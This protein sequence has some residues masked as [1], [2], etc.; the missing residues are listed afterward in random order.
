MSY[1]NFVIPAQ[2]A[3]MFD[4]NINHLKDLLN[5]T[6]KSKENI[7]NSNININGRDK[8]RDLCIANTYIIHNNTM[9]KMYNLEKMLFKMVLTPPK[10]NFTKILTNMREKFYQASSNAMETFQELVGLNVH[11]EN[12]YII[13]CEQFKKRMEQFTSLC[14]NIINNGGNVDN[15]STI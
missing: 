5:F 8:T 3:E 10:D 7:L 12:E 1:D 15:I 4:E 2:Y 9:I 13:I 14:D 6:N 11:N